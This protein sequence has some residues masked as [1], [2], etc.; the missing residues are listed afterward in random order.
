MTHVNNILVSTGTLFGNAEMSS[1]A[2]EIFTEFLE[3]KNVSVTLKKL[4]AARKVHY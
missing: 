1:A 2:M 4:E 3:N